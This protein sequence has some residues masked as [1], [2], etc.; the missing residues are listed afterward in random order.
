[1]ADENIGRIAEIRSSRKTLVKL[2]MHV[3]RTA[4]DAIKGQA[5]SVEQDG[6]IQTSNDRRSAISTRIGR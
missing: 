5:R 3:V 1:M 4:N 6:G 2:L